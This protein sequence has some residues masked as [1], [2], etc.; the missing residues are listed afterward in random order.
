MI[1]GVL[2]MWEIS[3]E[4]MNNDVKKNV[5]GLGE[6]PPWSKPTVLQQGCVSLVQ[7]DDTT[8]IKSP[9]LQ[10]TGSWTQL[11]SDTTE[12]ADGQ[13]MNSSCPLSAVQIKGDVL[14]F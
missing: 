10:A 8:D 2:S 12:H 5:R 13:N 11:W 3:R 14:M 1:A 7:T 4:C 6:W 9:K